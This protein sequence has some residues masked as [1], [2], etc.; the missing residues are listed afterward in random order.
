MRRQGKR[1][2]WV[3]GTTVGTSLYLPVMVEIFG[4]YGSGRVI[5]HHILEKLDHDP[6]TPH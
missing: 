1:Q 2:L 3:T 5:T 6:K 4:D